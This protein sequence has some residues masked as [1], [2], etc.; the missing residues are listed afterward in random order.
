MTT[1][2]NALAR[3][4]VALAEFADELVNA[5]NSFNHNGDDQTFDILTDIIE[6]MSSAI[7]EAIWDL[8][9]Q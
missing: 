3:V 5:E 1:K 9:D 6:A 8:E 2:A 7:I 4:Q